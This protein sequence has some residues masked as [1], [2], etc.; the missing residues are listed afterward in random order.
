MNLTNAKPAQ[1]DPADST[2]LATW[3][4]GV[5]ANAE[6]NARNVPGPRYRLPLRL[7]GPKRCEQLDP[8][9]RSPGNSRRCAR[10]KGHVIAK[11]LARA[12]D[13]FVSVLGTKSPR[14]DKKRNADRDR[15]NGTGSI[16]GL[17]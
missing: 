2:D 11:Y 12:D 10:T 14:I 1:R 7:D 5:G 6:R 17:T 15:V 4:F 9:L 3:G 16:G 13:G 8:E